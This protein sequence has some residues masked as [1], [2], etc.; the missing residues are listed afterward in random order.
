MKKK[1]IIFLIL[2]LSACNN[3][4]TDTYK[5]ING[6]WYFYD[7]DYKEFHANDSLIYL[8]DLTNTDRTIK[9][10]YV[11]RNDSLLTTPHRFSPDSDIQPYYWGRIEAFCKDS[12]LLAKDSDIITYYKIDES[13]DIYT[14]NLDYVSGDSLAWQRWLEYQ[15]EYW[16]RAKDY[17]KNHP[18]LK[19]GAE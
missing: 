5:T 19:I 1:T 10:D 9:L 13:E 7:K 4:Q 15:D 14:R 11:I 17:I 2:I 18:H 16:F 6:R 12:F 8:F 3:K